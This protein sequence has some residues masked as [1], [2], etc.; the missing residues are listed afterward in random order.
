LGIGLVLLSMTR[1][2]MMFYGAFL[3]LGLGAGGCTSV[4]VMTA[5]ANWFNKK[6]SFA[7]GLAAAGFGSGGL[8]VPIVVWMIDTFQ[9]RT[10]LATL[11]V[12]AWVIG[13]PLAMVVR[14]KPEKYGYLPDG[15]K[16]GGT[17]GHTEG[18]KE[19]VT[20]RKENAS[21]VG[22][23]FR[24][25]IRDSNFWYFNVAEAIRMMVVVS[26]IMHIMPYLDSLGMPRSIAGVAA[27]GMA[28]FSVAGRIGFGYIGDTFDKRYIMG[29]AYSL[30]VFG[31]VVFAS[32]IRDSGSLLLFLI[33]FAP[34]FGG[35]MTMRASLIREYFGT[36]AYGKLLGLSMG[37]G[38]TTAIIGPTLAGW[39]FDTTGTYRPLW[40]AYIGLM[41]VAVAL[42]LRIRPPN[43]RNG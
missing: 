25:A 39:T 5:V 17:A 19:S 1:S 20:Q 35:G 6:A 10:T 11:G 23:R 28:V 42:V 3:L 15:E 7:L 40:L 24:D 22:T 37:I 16:P 36:V 9:W 13:I 2:L 27:G 8:L 32:F 41:V 33:L 4:V 30:M 18:E 34:G 26:I 31:L 38:S 12:L 21:P 43:E 29:I 14:G